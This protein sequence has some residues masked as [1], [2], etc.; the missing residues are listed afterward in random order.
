MNVFLR[1]WAAYFRFGN[2]A[3][4]FDQIGS[5]A[6]ARSL[7]SWTVRPPS[8][9]RF[10]WSGGSAPQWPRRSPPPGD[11]GPSSRCG[12]AAVATSRRRAATA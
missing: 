5:Y 6:A 8:W 11:G 7:L 4:I 12:T 10:P 3:H 9:R 1:G 2:S